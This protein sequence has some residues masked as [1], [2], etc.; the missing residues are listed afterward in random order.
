[1]VVFDSSITNEDTSRNV[2]FFD[3]SKQVYVDGFMNDFSNTVGEDF[4]QN[5]Y[6]IRLIARKTSIAR[7]LFFVGIKAKKVAFKERGN[8]TFDWNLEKKER[9]LSFKYAN[10]LKK[11]L[12]ENYPIWELCL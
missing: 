3:K 7:A 6:K 2:P 10:I 5:F 1:M 4:D 11:R 8:L 12:W 9:R